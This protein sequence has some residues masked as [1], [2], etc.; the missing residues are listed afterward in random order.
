MDHRRRSEFGR[1]GT[2][3]KR[4]PIRP[5]FRQ[6]S[7]RTPNE[8]LVIINCMNNYEKVSWNINY[9]GPKMKIIVTLITKIF[10][11]FVNY[12]Y[13]Y[14]ETICFLYFSNF[15]FNSFWLCY[16]TNNDFQFQVFDN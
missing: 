16:L 9:Q 15:T 8:I 13:T 2:V 5:P 7:V 3:S 14:V 10:N 6:M 11:I 1:E 4:D 12:A